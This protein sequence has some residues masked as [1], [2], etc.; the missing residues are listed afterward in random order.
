MN[1]RLVSLSIG[2]NWCQEILNRRSRRGQQLEH[3]PQ[4]EQAKN[5]LQRFNSDAWVS[6]LIFVV[7]LVVF[8]MSPLRSLGETK[9]TLLVS[10]TL[11]TR[12]TFVLDAHQLDLGQIELIGDTGKAKDYP[13]EVIGGRIYKY[14]PPGSSVL[15]VPVVAFLRLF[16]VSVLD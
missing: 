12:G 11:L 3:L 15:S 5:V 14:A 7:A 2:L 16:G 4:E 13:L 6:L 1:V 9:Y 8:L 10:Q